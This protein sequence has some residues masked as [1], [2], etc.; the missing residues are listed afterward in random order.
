VS[1]LAAHIRQ[2]IHADGPISVEHFMALALSHPKY[3]YYMT[4]NPLGAEGDFV[5]SPEISQMFGELIGL[6][7]A[8]VWGGLNGPA[9]LNLVE[10]GP[11]RGT[12][13]CDALR[14]ARVA[15]LFQSALSVR[16]VE[17]SPVLISLQ[18]A[19]LQ[20][21]GVSATWHTHV[22]DVPSGP[23]VFIANEFFDALPVRHYVRTAQG[24]CERM[25]GLDAQGDL[26][27]GVSAQVEPHIHVEAP[28][29]SFLE[30]AATAQ[31]VMS[32]IAQRLV[33]EGGAALIIDYGYTQTRLGETLQ[34]MRAHKAV[35]PLLDP[36]EADLTAH[37]DFA[38]LARAAHAAGAAVY[39][40][41]LQGDFLAQLGI[42][43][44]A[45]SLKKNASPE[46]IRDIDA[47]LMRLISYEM[48]R[49]VGE[50]P[51]PGMGALFK[52]MAITHPSQPAPPG[53]APMR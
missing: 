35:D 18:R 22:S 19:A 21:M 30:V 38:A 34:A 48:E 50:A 7:T 1:Q 27:F 39:G 20:E 51:A 23:A 3:G 42:Y 9:V 44:R 13:M 24:W 36:G 11:G 5:T 25:V 46:Q 52:V 4:R 10:L 29:G 8:E 43:N 41:V 32:D 53:F 15:P 12:L 6:W 26:I 47:G 17:T 31:R 45:K 2:M 28:E 40:P 37:V 14:A 33:R 49:G 16:M